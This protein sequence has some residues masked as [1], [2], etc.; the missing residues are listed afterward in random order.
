MSWKNILITKKAR[1]SLR[2]SQLVC[3]TVDEKAYSFPLEDVASITLETPQATITSSLLTQLSDRAITLI[4]C[5][6]RHMPNGLLLPIGNHSRQL[7]VFN[8]QYNWSNPFK[9]RM[10]QIIVRQKIKNQFQVLKNSGVLEERI[11]ALSK[12]VDSGDTKNVE[13]QVAKIYFSSLFNNFKRHADDKTNAALN[14]GYSIVRAAIAREVV[15]FGFYPAVGIHHCNALNAFNLVDDLLEPFRP[16]VD[17]WVVANISKDNSELSAADR[18]TLTQVL[19]L[20]CV[21]KNKECRL[22]HAVTICVQSLS[23]ASFEKNYQLLKLPDWSDPARLKPL[24]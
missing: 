11:L 12:T 17:G 13:A 5:N 1:L 10:W 4:V 16:L 23:S 24:E 19:Q 6:N 9:K 7:S 2:H 3:Q 22:S 14:Y 18:A 21:L 15:R 8:A 20:A